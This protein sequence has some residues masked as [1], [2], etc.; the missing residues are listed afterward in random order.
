MRLCHRGWLKRGSEKGWELL[1]KDSHLS[2]N[3]DN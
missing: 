1:D 3:K 2:M